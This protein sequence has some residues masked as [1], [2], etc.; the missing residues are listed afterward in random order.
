[1]GHAWRKEDGRSTRAWYRSRTTRDWLSFRLA[2][3]ASMTVDREPLSQKLR[4][5]E[6][7]LQVRC[8]TPV[9]T[10]LV[11]QFRYTSAKH[12]HL[13]Q[14]LV[15]SSKLSSV[16]R[17][18]SKQIDRPAIHSTYFGALRQTQHV[19]LCSR[20]VRNEDRTEMKARCLP[21]S[22]S[23]ARISKI[24]SS[25]ADDVLAR[26]RIGNFEA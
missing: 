11:P 19:F 3:A 15:R 24:A 9:S 17:A 26:R 4:P 13:Q 23:P 1:M 22:C 18:A 5:R 12:L 20:T 25:A 16:M 21:L 8:T 14:A 10:V 6:I 2:T 7:V